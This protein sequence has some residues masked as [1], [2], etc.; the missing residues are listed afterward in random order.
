MTHYTLAVSPFGNFAVQRREADPDSREIESYLLTPIGNLDA[1]P[2][3]PAAT[4]DGAL[5]LDHDA[6]EAEARRQLAER[7]LGAHPFF[8]PRPL[9]VVNRAEYT[10]DLRATLF[11]AYPQSEDSTP[12][13]SVNTGRFDQSLTDSARTKLAAWWESVRDSI[14]TPEFLARD[15]VDRS[16]YAMRQTFRK[17][18]ETRD[19]A[20]VALAAHDL[21][22]IEWHAATDRLAAL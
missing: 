12:Y 5:W 15:A 8:A 7:N 4:K 17:V 21:A 16:E 1:V 19:A 13:W 18:E 9:Y 22:L 3:R 2:L 6:L 20:T 14:V 10:D 11:R